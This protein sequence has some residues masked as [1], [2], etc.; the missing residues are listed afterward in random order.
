[1]RHFGR[2]ELGPSVLARQ[3]GQGGEGR[4]HRWRAWLPLVAIGAGVLVV[5]L[6][7]GRGGG[8]MSSGRNAAMAP[9]HVDLEAHDDRARARPVTTPSAMAPHLEDRA[10]PPPVEPVQASPAGK[11]LRMMGPP[12]VIEVRI[13]RPKTDVKK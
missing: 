13:P 4:P 3:G 7:G 6:S 11:V 9:S 8:E 5:G 2:V 1:M 12:L 10:E